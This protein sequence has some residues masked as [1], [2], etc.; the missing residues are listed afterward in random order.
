LV[1][2]VTAT[3]CTYGAHGW[4]PH[5][6]SILIARPGRETA[7][8]LVETARAAWTKALRRE[9]LDC[10]EHGF[11]VQNATMAGNYVGKWGAAE[12]LSLGGKKGGKTGSYSPWQLLSI[13]GGAADPAGR[14]TKERAERMWVEYAAT[15]KGRRQLVWSEGLKAAARLA[16]QPDEA[17]A[18]EEEGGEV[19]AILDRAAWRGVAGRGRDL[20]AGLLEAAEAGGF[21]AVFN[22]LASHGIAAGRHPPGWRGGPGG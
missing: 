14:M 15:F 10:N 8:T 19:V 20:R 22:F 21:Q 13:A 4:H 11:Q 3:E 2:T 5:F 17:L 16:D 1:G 12:E 9:G 18:R 6:H 7:E